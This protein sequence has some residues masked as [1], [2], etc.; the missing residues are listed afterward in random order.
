[1]VSQNDTQAAD[2]TVE[3]GNLY[4]CSPSF[5]NGVCETTIAAGDTVTWDN[6]GGFHTATQCDASFTTCPPAG[7]F[8]SGTLSTGGTF[9]HTF[10]TAGTYP[11]YCA[12]HPTAMRG[13]VIVQA[14]QTA[15]PA[16]D[17]QT[18]ATAAP[19]QTA[20]AGNQST[21][22]G[23]TGTPGPVAGGIPSA[24]GPAGVSEG[25]YSLLALLAGVA[26]AAFGGAVVALT[27][28]RL[29]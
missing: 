3:A 7:G 25:E 13:R 16:P 14:V 20:A 9:A 12:L 23:G 2:V 6:V 17:A 28:R 11:Y 15:T 5:E 8:D 1:M 10:A 21:G 18:T 19:G 29:R 22:A 24:G 27:A 4:F 26:L